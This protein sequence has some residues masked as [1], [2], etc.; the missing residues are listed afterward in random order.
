MDLFSMVSRKA[1]LMTEKISYPTDDMS[2]TSNSLVSFLDDQWQQHTA[3]FLN[4]HDSYVA[5]LEAVA[6]LVPNA[7]SKAND[8]STA[9]QNYHQQYQQAYQTLRELATN[10][11]TAAQSMS[12]QDQQIGSNFKPM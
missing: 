3:L 4:N 11:D 2:T 6:K 5:L 9:L 7:G 1:N 8:L 12:G 10:I